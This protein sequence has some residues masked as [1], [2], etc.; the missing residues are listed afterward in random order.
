[1]LFKGIQ[2]II[3]DFSAVSTETLPPA[4]IYSASL[5]FCH[6]AESHSHSNNNALGRWL[7][8]WR[9]FVGIK[10]RQ[11]VISFSRIPRRAWPVYKQRPAKSCMGSCAGPPFPLCAK[12]IFF[13]HSAGGQVT[14][15]T[16]QTG[17]LRAERESAC[18]RW[19]GGG[20]CVSH[21]IVG[22]GHSIF[23]C[24][25]RACVPGAVLKL[26]SEPREWSHW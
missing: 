17:K 23:E 3:S 21:T 25:A 20:E 2:K 26:L 13:F 7:T 1:M 14:A 12:Q 18:T 15:L 4:C 9:S 5:L 16:L 11:S 8:N 22:M 24:V 19:H 10:T 6:P